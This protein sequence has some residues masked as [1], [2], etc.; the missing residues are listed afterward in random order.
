[1]SGYD[2]GENAPFSLI[3]SSLV[4]KQISFRNIH[5]P[6]PPVG[7]YCRFLQPGS[8]QCTA[9]PAGS[10]FPGRGA[11]RV[12]H[13]RGPGPAPAAGPPVLGG[14]YLP[15]WE[16]GVESCLPRSS[17]GR[18]EGGLRCANP[19]APGAVG[20]FGVTA[21][22]PGRPGRGGEG[23]S[24]KWERRGCRFPAHRGFPAPPARPRPVWGP[25]GT[26]GPRRQEPPPSPT[27]A[28]PSAASPGAAGPA[29]VFPL[30]P[31][32]VVMCRLFCLQWK[33]FL[34]LDSH[35]GGRCPWGA[36]GGRGAGGPMRAAEP[37]APG[38]PR[39]PRGSG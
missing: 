17:C 34:A 20:A 30:S 35:R 25:A 21:A 18:A 26:A 24:H 4:L 19:R 14:N 32:S 9:V 15:P 23:D 5:S 36:R 27:P 38:P 12:P 6:P 13:T 29:H 11:V 1:M 28:L 31:P 8:L 16:G 39:H 33:Q 22:Q 3:E 10:R 2:G 37:R 7:S